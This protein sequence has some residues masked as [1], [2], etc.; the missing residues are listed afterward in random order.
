MKIANGFRTTPTVIRHLSMLSRGGKI[1]W[2]DG[3]QL[4]G[5][6]PAI[7]FKNESHRITRPM[8]ANL[9]RRWLIEEDRKDS[10][11][12]SNLGRT[13]LKAD[14]AVQNAKCANAGYYIG[15]EA[16]VRDAVAAGD[17]KAT[18]L[19][20]LQIDYFKQ[21]QVEADARVR[22]AASAL[23]LEQRWTRA[24]EAMAVQYT[25]KTMEQMEQER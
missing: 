20:Q 3:E 21:W 7:V 2:E 19:R 9:E 10:Y 5:Q 22:N 18:E 1:W 11:K 13:L 8:L 17:A 23:E 15:Y 24:I 16:G 12:I 25:G 6:F 14:K 4:S